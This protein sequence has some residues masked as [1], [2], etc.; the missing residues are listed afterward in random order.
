MPTKPAVGQVTH[1]A[2]KDLKPDPTQP[3]RTYQQKSLTELAGDLKQHGVIQPLTI[4]WENG[5]IIV[6]GERRWRASQIAKLE[7]VPCIL[8][9]TPDTIERGARQVSENLHREDLHPLDLAEYLDDLRKREGKTHNELVKALQDKG[10]TEAGHLKVRQLLDLVLLPKWV[11]D[12][13]RQGKL[14]ETVAHRLVA[15]VK[16]PEIMK[17]AKTEIDNAIK[18]RD[19]LSNREARDIVADAIR[20]GG[21]DL[22]WQ[23]GDEARQFPMS[24]CNGCEFKVKSGHTNYCVNPAEFKKKNDA[25]LKLLADEKRAEDKQAAERAKNGKTTKEEQSLQASKSRRK[26]ELKLEKIE[27]YLDKWLRAKMLATPPAL[28]AGRTHALALWMA[29]GAPTG[30]RGEFSTYNQ[31][32]REENRQTPHN[33]TGVFMKDWKLGDLPTFLNL[34][35]NVARD[36]WDDMARAAIRCMTM[37]QLRSFA[38][39]LKVDLLAIGFAVDVDYLNLLRSPDL[40]KLAKL[41]KLPDAKGTMKELKKKILAPASVKLIGVPDDLRKVYEKAPQAEKALKVDLEELLP[42][43][44]PATVAELGRAASAAATSKKPAKKVAGKRK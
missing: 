21:I 35:E 33:S 43:P 9:E 31:D 39:W 25:A 12:Y 38:H 20:S 3:R 41:G 28:P 22:D 15:L 27:N 5:P 29:C 8:I 34:P 37:E 40:L 32:Y 18:W 16:W 36:T 6:H 17:A 14:L 4:R 2:P 19:G 11:K 42:P 44:S 24:A 13:M 1:F 7:T 23:H 10:L 30:R 26:T